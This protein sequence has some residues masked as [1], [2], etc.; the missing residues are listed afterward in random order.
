MTTPHEIMIHPRQQTHTPVHKSSVI[1]T[2][3]HDIGP[4]PSTESICTR[5]GVV[6]C[7]CF[8]PPPPLPDKESGRTRASEERKER[9]A[10]CS[11]FDVVTFE[12]RLDIARASYKLHGPAS[13]TCIRS[14]CIYSRT[15]VWIFAEPPYA[16]VCR[17]DTN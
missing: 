9:R 16:S 17:S 11:S 10:P 12:I 3:V 1:K 8:L 14:S 7:H 6:E 13:M 5:D 15:D 2:S 4:R